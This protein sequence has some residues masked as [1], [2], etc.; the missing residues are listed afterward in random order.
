MPSGPAN[1]AQ[2]LYDGQQ[3]AFSGL[4]RRHDLPPYIVDTY[5]G[6]T[7]QMALLP[8][9]GHERGHASGGTCEGVVRILNP[10]Q[11]HGP[12][13]LVVSSDT[14]QR[15]LQIVVGP[16]RLAIRLRMVNREISRGP[17]RPLSDTISMFT[18]AWN[19][20]RALVRLKGMGRYSKWPS[21]VF[22]ILLPV[23]VAE[24]QFRRVLSLSTK[25]KPAP[26]GDEGWINPAAR[27]L[28]MYFSMASRSKWKIWRVEGR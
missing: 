12:G 5:E 14:T 22:S 13:R 2:G 19:T 15:R 25:K 28:W 11:V 18:R 4:E 7:G 16:F 23:P 26:T 9:G 20:A 21:R 27:E 17:Q 8:Q 1:R 24:V 6:W 3:C 10:R